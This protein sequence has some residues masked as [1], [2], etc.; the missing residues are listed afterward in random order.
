MEEKKN[1]AVCAGQTLEI[2]PRIVRARKALGMTKNDLAKELNVSRAAVSNWEQ[3]RRLPDV[4]TL[5]KLSSVLHVRF[6]V[7]EAPADSAL[8]SADAPAASPAASP[9]SFPQAQETEPEARGTETAPKKTANRRMKFILPAAAVLLLALL[10]VFLIPS[11]SRTVITPYKAADGREYLPE[12]F[13]AKSEPADG[14]SFL[15]ATVTFNS[16]VN[17]TQNF[18]QY[19]FTFNEKNGVPFTIDRVEIVVFGNK[20][21]NMPY[22]FQKEDLEKYQL[23]TTIEANGEW[24][25][26]GGMPD[27]EAAEGV[28]LPLTGRSGNDGSPQQFTGYRA[29]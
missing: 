7:N 24:S 16:I 8:P 20:G 1:P 22:V 10:A 27:Q 15:K 23:A 9:V 14:R 2:G 3:D 25:I 12:D 21:R 29:F 26:S 18:T 5:K 19:I 17:D 28:G 4:M 13:R 6:D 11:R